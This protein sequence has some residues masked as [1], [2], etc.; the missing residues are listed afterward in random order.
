MTSDSQ[1]HHRQTRS[2][3]L[4]EAFILS[5]MVLV[6]LAFGSAL[7]VQFG[8]P[9]W[10]SALTSLALYAA[11]VSIHA[12]VRRSATIRELS[13]EIWRL[14]DEVSLIR[15]RTAFVHQV[16]PAAA[17]TAQAATR[18]AQ[19]AP[20]ANQKAMAD[21]ARDERPASADESAE[22]GTPESAIAERSAPPT[23]P[24]AEPSLKP[25]AAASKPAPA[26]EKD[27]AARPP[28]AASND[29]AKTDARLTDRPELKTTAFELTT[30]G[31]KSGAPTPATSQPVAS[32][33]GAS[34][35]GFWAFRPNDP[36]P[37]ARA[38]DAQ[39]AAATRPADDAL[40]PT[41]L[42]PKTAPVTATTTPP[43]TTESSAAAA[44]AIAGDVDAIGGM[45]R[46]FAEEIGPPT[47]N[48]SA[49][50]SAVPPQVPKTETVTAH[51]DIDQSVDALRTAA[52]QM[53]RTSGPDLSTPLERGVLP[54]LRPEAIKGPLP[55]P[56]NHSHARLAAVADSIAANRFDVYL[57]PVVALADRKVRHYEIALRLRAEPSGSLGASDYLPIARDAG[58]LPLIDCVAITRA[59]TM[60]RHMDNR[61]SGGSLFLP[62]TG[63]SLTNQG[64]QWEFAEAC[65]HTTRLS[66]RLVLA[67][68]QADIRAFSADHW[69]AIRQ[70]TAA[71]FKL[72]IDDTASFDPDL[73][74]LKAKGFS[75]IRFT[76]PTL[77]EGIPSQEGPITAAVLC[78]RLPGIGLAP[79][80]K[81]IETEAQF[82]RM[83]E[84]GLPL[85]QG[86]LFGPR[87]PVKAQV[88]QPAR[89][90]VAA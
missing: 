85:G 13:D 60:A 11:L 76:A 23:P 26:S 84:L 75:F 44:A 57:E 27:E 80:V 87:L 25:A 18:E 72:A 43:Q 63:E 53:R 31:S 82:A 29:P 66:E 9:L 12:L 37:S 77:M 70:I 79:M 28:D 33:L 50:A 83:M 35:R 10:I 30:D 47:P 71:G 48:A 54:P 68:N 65:R 17:M 6:T 2:R 39:A 4:R 67:F 7:I 20:P 90:V 46:K 45:I 15:E 21:N 19:P 14:E 8:L 32:K 40:Q 59:A 51:Q 36:K 88:L 55:P 41:A 3:P 81:A 69:D 73:A 52:G 62:L 64:F 78:Q 34:M 42:A 58:M 1:S 16:Q 5:A 22:E 86:P 74:D 49:T 38:H 61:S 24:A 56:V 89:N